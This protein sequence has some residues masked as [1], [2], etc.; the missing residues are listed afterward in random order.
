M[1]GVVN[2]PEVLVGKYRVRQNS[3]GQLS[4]VNSAGVEVA[5]ITPQVVT[6]APANP[7]GTTSTVGVMAGLGVAFTPLSTGR[8]EVSIAGNAANSAAGDGAAFQI[9]YGTGAA[10]ANG[11]ALTGTAAGGLAQITSGAAGAV[12]SVS[13]YAI[14]T[15]LTVGTAYYFD[16]SEAAVTGGT[17]SITALQVNIIEF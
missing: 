13:L 2:P 15:G 6:A 1:V 16:I 17:A 12:T 3:Q 5:A 10:P 4:I 11:A 8:V 7:A 14:I 9:R